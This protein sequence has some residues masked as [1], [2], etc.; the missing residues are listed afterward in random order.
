MDHQ[1]FQRDYFNQTT[2]NPL[3]AGIL[4]ILALAM[5]LVPRRYA[6]WPMLIMACFVSPAQRVV[7][8]TLDFTFLR[9]LVCVGMVR[10]LFRGEVRPL[11]FNVLDWMIVLYTVARTVTMYLLFMTPAALI[12]RL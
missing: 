6:L 8:A 2:I 10:I 11:R 1:H 3:G 5:L 4:V 7:I 12:N 9:V